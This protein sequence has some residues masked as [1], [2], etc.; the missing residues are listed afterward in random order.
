MMNKQ[1][2]VVSIAALAFGTALVS[3]PALAQNYGRAANDGGA[4]SAPSGGAS[5]PLYNSVPQS[6][7]STPHYGRALDDGGTVDE[8]TAAQT[9]ASQQGSQ[10]STAN[11]KPYYGRAMN[12]GG[13]Q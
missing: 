4:V 13:S 1:K 3:A 2:V 6:T 5:Q 9:S 8:P 11:Q 12:D 7:P 10:T